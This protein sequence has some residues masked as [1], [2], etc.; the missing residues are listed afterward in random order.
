MRLIEEIKKFFKVP[1]NTFLLIV[2]PLVFTL[3]FGFCYYNDYLND[4]PTAVLDM[5]HSTM[6]RMIIKDFSDSDRYQVIK[7]AKSTEELKQLIADKTVHLGLFI[8]PNFSADIK[9]KRGTSALMMIDGSNIA[10]GNNALATGT[11]ILNTINA[12]VA[13]KVIESKNIPPNQAESY[14][15]LFQ[16]QSRVLWDSKL[17]YK[18]YMMPGML[19][20]L[21]QQMF[22]TVFIPNFIED[23]RNILQ[24]CL[25]HVVVALASFCISLYVLHDIVGVKFIGNEWV[26]V[27]L[28]GVYLFCL[29]G[30]SMTIGALFKD[31]QKAT[32]F[33]MM[34]SMP[35][36]L[37]SGYMWP[38]YAMPKSVLYITKVIWPLIYIIT[39]IKDILIKDTPVHFFYGQ[40]FQML[41]FGVVWF[42]IGYYLVKKMNPIVIEEDEEFDPQEAS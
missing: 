13:M 5:D 4:I 30:V 16:F 6:S 25:V 29:L 39:P 10:M 33:C 35:T 15:K 14:A 18:Y 28:M 36:L 1:K 37:T 24:K 40:L 26:A 19:I 20:V 42:F 41:I 31:R 9:A 11:E 3:I 7:Y 34:L 38:V 32:Q 2:G 21:I 23:K 8:P 22:L 12:G 17:S 27:T